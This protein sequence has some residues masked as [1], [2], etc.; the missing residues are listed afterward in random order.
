MSDSWHIELTSSSTPESTLK[1][2][3]IANLN[4]S[5]NQIKSTMQVQYLNRHI[6]KLLDVWVRMYTQVQVQLQIHIY[7]G[8]ETWD[9]I[10]NFWSGISLKSVSSI[11]QRR[12]P[13]HALFRTPLKPRTRRRLK[14]QLKSTIQ[15]FTRSRDVIVIVINSHIPSEHLAPSTAPI[16]DCKLRRIPKIANMQIAVPV[17]AIAALLLGIIDPGLAQTL[18][19][20]GDSLSGKKILF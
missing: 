4:L 12:S 18:T 1:S 16:E 9:Q 5:P 2:D 10:T 11:L 14:F 7:I 17:L 13:G 20:F 3:L 15:K 19:V 6:F 8:L